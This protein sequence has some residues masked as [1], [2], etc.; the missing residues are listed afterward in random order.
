MDVFFRRLLLV[1]LC[2]FPA[3]AAWCAGQAAALPDDAAALIWQGWKDRCTV[4][5]PRGVIVKDPWSGKCLSEAMGHGLLLAVQMNDQEFFDRVL[6]GLG[7]YFTNGNGLYA[8]VIAPDGSAL[9]DPNLSV[10]ASESEVNV[11]FALLQAGCLVQ[12]GR[13][14]NTRPYLQAAGELEDRIWQCEVYLLGKTPVLLPSDSKKNPY[15]PLVTTKR[16]HTVRRVAWAPTYMNPAFFKTFAAAFPRHDWGRL[17]D[18]CYELL[19]RILDDSD[20]L[21]RNDLGVRG[22]NPVPAWVYLEPGRR[23]R[24]DVANYFSGATYEGT[25]F[26]NEYDSIRIPL[27]VGLDWMWH[28]DERAWRFLQRFLALSGVQKPAQAFC[29][30]TP[31]NKRGFC[32]VLSVSQFGLAHKVAG[33]GGPFKDA[34][35]RYVNRAKRCFGADPQYYYNQTFALYAYL[36]FTDRLEPVVAAAPAPAS[37]R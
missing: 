35:L 11:L 15:W 5:L 32:E 28:R 8:W 18:A 10:S 3:R 19:E 29:G 16:S 12:Q 14:K 37:A 17:S 26:S 7:A 6:D 13:W 1:V 25:R 2:L 20:A 23:E 31:A 21:L 4:V 9:P 33:E 30:A 24:I 22:V 34:T 36:A 27:Y